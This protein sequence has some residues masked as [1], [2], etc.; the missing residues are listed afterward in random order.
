MKQTLSPRRRRPRGT[1]SLRLRAPGKWELRFRDVSEQVFAKNETEARAKLGA[2]VER[3]R[4]GGVE[5]A[6]RMTF[7]QLADAYLKDKARWKAATTIAWY[8]RNLSQH[9][10]PVI[11]AVPILDLRPAHV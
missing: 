5:A 8:T 6:E 2:F 10:R 9:V 4:N 7:G 1:G 11:V 3:M